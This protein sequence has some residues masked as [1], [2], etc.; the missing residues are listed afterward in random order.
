MI[1]IV[2]SASI[3]LVI[4]MTYNYKQVRLPRNSVRLPESK[5]MFKTEE[6][7]VACMM[8]M[9]KEATVA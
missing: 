1:V 6:G 2:V 9:S 7:M 3:I 5:E 4:I 8:R